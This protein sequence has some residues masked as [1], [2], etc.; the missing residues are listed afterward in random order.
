MQSGTGSTPGTT[1]GRDKDLENLFKRHIEFGLPINLS[2]LKKQG[3]HSFF[4]YNFKA[5]C[6]VK[7]GFLEVNIYL[8]D[9]LKEIL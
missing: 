1:A 6:L 7:D 9:I 4:Y 8:S 5:I 2:M 3:K